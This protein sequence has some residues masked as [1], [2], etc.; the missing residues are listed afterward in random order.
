MTNQSPPPIAAPARCR[1]RGFTLIELMIAVAVVSV[2]T[3][4][5]LPSYRSSV[6]KS[7]R[8]EAQ[9][10]LLAVAGRQQQFMV[11]RRSFAASVAEAGI[12]VPSN[13]AA[14]YTLSVS[15]LSGP[16]PT[17]SL[18]AVPKGNQVDETCGTLGIDQAGVKTGAAAGCW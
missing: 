13:V 5:A 11:D 15:V 7:V 9:S 12:A 2:L 18:R 10:F 17:F 16:P 6:R 8:A 14:A 1:T 3:A 4:V